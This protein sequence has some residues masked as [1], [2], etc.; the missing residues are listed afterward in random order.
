MTYF[1]CKYEMCWVCMK[2][3]AGP[4][5]DCKQKA[6]DNNVQESRKVT[7]RCMGY[8]K[9]YRRHKTSLEIES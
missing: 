5:Y 4:H 2:G 8:H 9:F 1:K 6:E 7:K 3:L